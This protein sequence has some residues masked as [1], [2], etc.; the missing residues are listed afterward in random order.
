M[1]SEKDKNSKRKEEH[2][3]FRKVMATLL[4]FIL[5]TM[6]IEN[7]VA[8]FRVGNLASG[9]TVTSGGHYQNYS[10]DKAVDGQVGIESS[11][12]SDTGRT[13]WIQVDLG[14]ETEFNLW[15][16]NAAINRNKDY[17]LQTSSDGI[18]FSDIPDANAKVTG[19]DSFDTYLLL[20]APVKSRYVRVNFTDTNDGH[21]PNIMEFGL[22]HMKKPE[23]PENVKAVLDKDRAIIRF[24]QPNSYG[25][26]ITKYTVTSHP[27]NLTATGTDS[28]ITVTGLS[29]DTEYTF[30]VTATSEIGESVP[31]APSNAITPVEAAP[32]KPVLTLS[33]NN[34]TN[35]DVKVTMAGEPG[36]TI[37][38]KLNNGSW[39][40][41]TDKITVST[42]GITE[43][44]A[45][46]VNGS[47]KK[48]DEEKVEVRIDKTAPVIT[49]NGD[50]TMTLYK[51]TP[52]TDPGVTITDRESGLKAEVQGY[53]LPIQTGR[54][55]LKYHAKDSAGNI[56]DV[57]TRIVN[58]V[59]KPTPPPQPT[60]YPIS[61]VTLEEEAFTMTL[62]DEPVK[63]EATIKP[64][65]ASYKAVEWTSSN[66]EVAEVDKEGNVT[67][68]SAGK[69]TITVRTLDGNKTASSE[70]TVK[71]KVTF[72]LEASPE[73]L[74]L[75]PKQSKNLKVY[76]RDGKKRK[77]ITNDKETTY[78]IDND[79]ISLKKGRIIAGETEGESVI[80]VQYQGEELIIPVSV[81]GLTLQS[82]QLSEPTLILEPEQDKQLTLTASFSDKSSK[83]VTEKA[84]WTSS[85]P[86]V[87][88]VL[89]N[90]EIKAVK[91]GKAYVTVKYDNQYT[92]ARVLVVDD[93]APKKLKLNRSTL[94]LSPEETFTL[95]VHAEYERGYTELV[96]DEVEWVSENP[97]VAT[98]DGGEVTVVSTG[99]TTLTGSYGGKEVTV[100]VTVK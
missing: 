61:E 56:A 64:T 16:V 39:Q 13:G 97:E 47:Q 83:D 50:A 3:H 14:E 20:V 12:I 32:S 11:W 35:Q 27:G 72:T 79:L 25:K 9:K 15:E 57:V 37:Q 93:K 78:S 92:R 41:Y 46:A 49:L 82:I 70:V 66:P 75:K 68:K 30:T 65:Y 29:Y 23:P 5:L 40:T 74:T 55:T 19:N 44:V 77:D 88:E 2:L 98:V 90:G 52:F 85:D 43:V 53:I 76:V 84:T 10:P 34:W 89:K 91:S 100:R 71:R 45:V 6:G 86:D 38:Y 96:S 21:N 87:L 63:L 8:A 48:S 60:Y 67:A 59:N 28:P 18:I 7:P 31:S 99:S 51:G 80:T 81:S 73:E 94:R 24:S 42:E 33:H 17:S 4:C 62:G 36:N 1:T 58:V 54:Y 26:P 95:L 22:Y 69:T